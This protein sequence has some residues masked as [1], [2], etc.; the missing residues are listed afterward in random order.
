MRITRAA[1]VAAFP[2]I[3]LALVAL[4]ACQG[5]VGAAGA[6]GA[7][8]APGAPGRDAP[9][10]MP[11]A[12]KADV[13]LGTQYFALASIKPNGTPALG[14]NKKVAFLEV[15]DYFED[16]EGVANLNYS[17]AKLSADDT[18]IVDAY[19]TDTLPKID[20]TEPDAHFFT[21]PVPTPVETV[22]APAYLVIQAKAKGTVTL[23][24]MVKDGL[25]DGEATQQITVMVRASNAG[26]IAPDSVLTVPA[27]TA[28]SRVAV[29]RIASTGDVTVK[30]PDGAFF[31]ADGDSLIVTAAVGGST[32]AVTDANKKFL[33]VSIDA[34][35]DLVLTPKKGGPPANDG[36][37]P[38]ILT[39]TDPYGKTVVTEAT[40]EMSIQV[41][42][43]TAPMLDTYETNGDPLPAGKAVGDKKALADIAI[44]DKTF[45]VGE[46]GGED[47]M[48]EDFI[49]LATYFVDPDDEDVFTGSEGIC[50]FV[51]VPADQKN[52]KVTFDMPREKIQI[53]ALK[54]GSVEV[55]VTCTD[56]KEESVTDRVTATIRN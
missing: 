36:T 31:D 2:L 42:V 11:P 23:N 47:K 18:K 21:P 4:V 10:N 30:V 16:P 43:N 56:G 53:T 54:R 3:V 29:N 14:G 13:T 39:A 25:P 5:P 6:Q 1:K 32:A 33:D 44:A 45:N 9:Q 49:A 15:S 26:P 37:I 20:M 40:G 38:V 8:G 50:D 19:L 12:L 52:A 35:G 28:M 7:A 51:T 24:L 27:F 34:N 46:D 22:P 17:L 41:K 48:A 55:V